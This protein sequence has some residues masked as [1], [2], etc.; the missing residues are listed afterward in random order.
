MAIKPAYG[1]SVGH[2]ILQMNS[3]GERVYFTG[4]VFHH[5]VQ[6]L[7]PELDLGGVDDMPAAIATRYRLREEIAACE[8]LFLPAHFPP[9]HGGRIER[10][11]TE[12]VFSALPHS[13]V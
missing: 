1:H 3:G 8:A 4:D 13:Q 5:P 2:S 12:Y 7:Q 6:I 10:R 9:P 11:G